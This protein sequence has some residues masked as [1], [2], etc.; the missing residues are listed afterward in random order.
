MTNRETFGVEEVAAIA[1]VA[2]DPALLATKITLRTIKKKHPELAFHLAEC[3]CAL[4]GARDTKLKP[5]TPNEFHYVMGNLAAI[6]L[7]VPGDKKE[8]GYVDGCLASLADCTEG[9]RSSNWQRMRRLL[10]QGREH[11]GSRGRE[12]SVATFDGEK[13][14]E[15]KRQTNDLR[16]LVDML[17]IN[18]PVGIDL[19]G[20]PPF[21]RIQT[22]PIEQPITISFG[23]GKDEETM[24]I[25]TDRRRHSCVTWAM[26]EEGYREVM[27]DSIDDDDMAFVGEAYHL[28]RWFGHSFR[29]H[30]P[31]PTTMNLGEQPTASWLSIVRRRGRIALLLRRPRGIVTVE[32]GD[33]IWRYDPTAA[34]GDT[35][36]TT[37]HESLKERLNYL[38]LP[39]ENDEEDTVL[40]P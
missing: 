16:T 30:I 6:D 19:L 26:H 21:E 17:A 2:L 39:D 22:L 3:L 15:T 8:A 1:E 28:D 5:A 18:V 11:G 13:R 23:E 38:E 20:K 32:Q 4:C 29:N 34:H 36:G 35:F 37:A 25:A 9:E 14:K 24:R 12:G 31:L 33:N 10:A 40:E 7:G 27:Q